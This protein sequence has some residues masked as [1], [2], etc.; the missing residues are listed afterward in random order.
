MVVQDDDMIQVLLIT[1]S[2]C[3]GCDIMDDIILSIRNT[4]AITKKININICHKDFIDKNILIENNITDFP[5]TII[6]DNNYKQSIVLLG[7]VP[8]IQMQQEINRLINK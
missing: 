6:Y 4:Y 7:T 8:F 2:N 3:I 1:Q 5:A